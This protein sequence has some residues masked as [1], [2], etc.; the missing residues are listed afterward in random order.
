VHA[1]ASKIIATPYTFLSFRSF[2][3][4]SPP[5]TPTPPTT[6]ATATSTPP[7][8]VPLPPVTSLLPTS[9]FSKFL[10]VPGERSGPRPSVNHILASAALSLSAMGVVSYVHHFAAPECLPYLFGL[11]N[12]VMLI[13]SFGASSALVFGAPDSPVAQPRCVIFGH[14]LSASVGVATGALL[15]NYCDVWVSGPISVSLSIALMLAT[16]TFHPPAASNGLIY[17][18]GGMQHMG[19]HYI[20]TPCFL[21]PCLIVSLGVILNNFLTQRRYPKFWL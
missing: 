7:S 2:S 16:R 19:W 1:R 8:A 14:M 18:M 21:G 20:I 9:Y 6:A 15:S 10:G 4:S 12:P 5:P 17:L 11:D 3:S 13:G